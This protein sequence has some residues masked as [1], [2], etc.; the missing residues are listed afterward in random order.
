MSGRGGRMTKAQRTAWEGRQLAT[1]HCVSCVLP[2]VN[3]R[4]CAR[5]RRMAYAKVKRLKL[6][7]KAAGLC[8]DCGAALGQMS[9]RL[10]DP[11]F[12]KSVAYHAT[13]LRP[14]R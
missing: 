12:E 2:A 7:R 1:G 11:H 8:T 4:H 3:R 9:T 14:E 6:A 10:C 13:Y 5:H